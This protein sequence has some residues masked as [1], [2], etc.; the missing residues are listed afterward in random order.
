MSASVSCFTSNLTR[1]F[2]QLM[3]TVASL[4]E[5]VGT[6]IVKYSILLANVSGF[7]LNLSKSKSAL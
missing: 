7:T 5:K 3:A 2:S 1:V 6:S 4:L